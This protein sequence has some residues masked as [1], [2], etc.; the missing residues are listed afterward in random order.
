MGHTQHSAQPQQL[1][2]LLLLRSSCAVPAVVAVAAMQ[3][4]CLHHLQQL[5][6]GINSVPVLVSRSVVQ[7]PSHGCVRQQLV[8]Y[9]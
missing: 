9:D 2:Q 7:K 5:E 3:L 4:D 6:Q 1:P 8:L